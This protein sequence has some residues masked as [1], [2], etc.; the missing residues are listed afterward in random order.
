MSSQTLGH[1][2]E[3]P[4]RRLRCHIKAFP[5]IFIHSQ[6][7]ISQVT[8]LIV[9]THLFTIQLESAHHKLSLQYVLQSYGAA[10]IVL[11]VLL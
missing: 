8:L 11:N 2:P 7:P 6:I 3:L 5:S 10:V 1:T 9:V 4:P